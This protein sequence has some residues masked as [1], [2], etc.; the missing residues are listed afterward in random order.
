MLTFKLNIYAYL[1]FIKSFIDLFETAT[2][3]KI[4]EREKK[5]T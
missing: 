2:V 4:L 5:V 1:I 3:K